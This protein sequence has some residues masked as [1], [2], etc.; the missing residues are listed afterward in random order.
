MKADMNP[1]AG[2]HSTASD[3]FEDDSSSQ[4]DSEG[5]LVDDLPVFSGKSKTVAP[6]MSVSAEVFGKF[7]IEK[8]YIPPKHPKSAE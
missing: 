2:G 1:N 7:N 4:S 8:E 3:K 6:R 5:E